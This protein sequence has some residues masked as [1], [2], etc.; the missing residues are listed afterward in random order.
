MNKFLSFLFLTIVLA[1]FC[2]CEDEEPVVSPGDPDIDP[3]EQI[4]AT[5]EEEAELISGA[6]DF[7]FEIFKRTCVAQ[8]DGEN[9]F[10]SPFSV[11][12]AFSMLNNGARGDSRAAITETLGLGNLSIDQINAAYHDVYQR[13]IELD[14]A[15][16]VDIANSIWHDNDGIVVNDGFVQTN[17]TYY[18]ALVTA[19][20]FRNPATVDLINAWVS[21]NTNGKIESILDEIGAE[22]VMFLINAI[23]FKG[24]WATPFD[25][26]LTQESGFITEAGAVEPVEMMSESAMQRATYFTENYKAVELAYGDS[27]Y[28][29]TL[30]RPEDN[31]TADQLAEDFNQEEWNTLQ[32]GLSLSPYSNTILSLPKLDLEY[33]ISYNDI[34]SAMGMGVLFGSSADLTGIGT[35]GGSLYV[36]RVQHKSYLKLDEAGTE[37]AAVTAIGVGV[38]SAPPS[39]RFN[40]PFLM[41]ISEKETGAILFMGKIEN[42]AI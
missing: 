35:A 39:I 11:S 2:S 23:Y 37:A 15:V 14:P 40:K 8:E 42:P 9:V 20:D 41:V 22:E 32:A 16:Q 24:L 19:E 1:A 36:S 7:C 17:E 30:I 3:I 13:L 27:I 26:E 12:M 34:L 33:E 5:P 6:N 29:M 28:T 38:T 4:F 18:D 10:I 25:P 21:D 31:L